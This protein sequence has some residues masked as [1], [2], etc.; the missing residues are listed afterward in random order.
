MEESAP[1]PKITAIILSYNAAPALRRCLTALEASEGREQLEIIVVDCGSMDE[2]PTLDREFA[3]ITLLRL[4]RNFGATK[5][6]NIGMRTA[7]ADYIF[8]LSPDVIVEPTTAL[9][10]AAYLDK[11]EAA[12][13]VCPLLVD[14]KGQPQ[15]AYLRLPSPAGMSLLWQDPDGLPTTPVDPSAEAVAVEYPGR[16]ALAVRKY[17][18]KAINWLDDRYG[19]FGGDLEIAYQL[20]RSRRKIMV[21]PAIRATLVTSEPLPFDAAALATIS[22]DRAHGISVFL[23]KHFGWFAGFTFQVKA[24][25]YALTHLEFRVLSALVSGKKID[26]SQASM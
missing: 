17:F 25:L 9:A 16:Q 2:S 19:E 10:L 3:G 1:Q 4:E 22:A 5:A 7:A 23:G 6:L 20:W 18:V 12:G 21:V 26:G 24:V 14:E 15:A 8:F 11:D 13:A